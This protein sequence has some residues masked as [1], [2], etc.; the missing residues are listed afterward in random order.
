MEKV[1][2][3]PSWIVVR[4]RQTLLLLAILLAGQF[5]A[6]GQSTNPAPYCGNTFFSFNSTC[7]GWAAAFE[8]VEFNKLNFSGPACPSANRSS[9]YSYWDKASF[10]QYTTSVVKG[11]SYDISITTSPSTITTNQF[12]AFVDWNGDLDF[13]DA[14]EQIIT[15]QN[16]PFNTTW[17]YTRSITVPCGAKTGL[18]RMRLRVTPNFTVN[19]GTACNSADWG[20]T[21]DYDITIDAPSNPVANFFIPDT[22]FTNSPATFVNAN[23]SGYISHEWSTS[24]A[25]LPTIVGTNTNFLFAFPSAGTY[26]VRLT[27]A[28]CIGSATT[29]KNIVVVDP[30]TAPT[31]RFVG[32]RNNILVSPNAGFVSEF[33]DYYDF[34]SSGPTNYLWEITATNPGAFF[35]PIIG[36][37]NDKNV[38]VLFSD[39]ANHE[40]CMTASNAIGSTKLCK[41]DYLIIQYPNNPSKYE[42]IICDDAK[43]TLDSGVVYDPGGKDDPY[44]STTGTCQFVIDL[45]DADEIEITIPSIGYFVNWGDYLRVYDGADIS[46]K[47]LF[48]NGNNTPLTKTQTI[49]AKSGKATIEFQRDAWDAGDGFAVTWKAKLRNDGPIKAGIDILD[50]LTNDSIYNCASGREVRF[51]NATTNTRVIDYNEPTA[52]QWIFDYDPLIAYPA[53]FEDMPYN[54]DEENPTYVYS[55]DNKYT[56]RLVV[57]SCEG[58]DTAYRTLYIGTGSSVPKIDFVADATILNV[59]E[60]TWLRDKTIGWCSGTWSINPSTYTVKNGSLTDQDVEIQFNKAA[61][62][63]IT[64]ASTNDNGSSSRT[65]TDYISVIEYCVPSVNLSLSSASITRVKLNTMEKVSAT[66]KDGYEDFSSTLSTDLYAGATYTIEVDRNDVFDQADRKVWIDYNRDGAFSAS[67]LVASDANATT[68]TLT[69]SIT[70]PNYK[71]FVEGPT[72]MRVALGLSGTSLTP[73]GPTNV[74]EYEDYRVML[75]RDDMP[76]VITVLGTDSVFI[77]LGSS[78]KD[79]G[80]TAFDNR[81]GNITHKI[82]VDNQVDSTQTGVYVVT[83]NVLDESG[84][85]ATQRIRFVFVVADFTKPVIS[86][87]GNV[88]ETHE[89]NTPY[90]DAGATAMDDPGANNI[91]N[92]I[93]TANGVDETTLGTYEVE[94]T[95]TDAY[96]NTSTA[97]RTVNVVDRTAPVIT[98]PPVSYAIQV[99]TPFNN[100]TTVTDNYDNSVQLQVVSGSVSTSVFGTYKVTYTAVDASGNVAA[101][102]TCTYTVTDLIAPVVTSRSGTEFMLVNVNDFAFV[103][104]AVTATDNY[105]PAVAITRT[106]SFDI[107][108]LGDYT[109]TYTGVDGAGNTGTYVR[110]LRVVDMKAPTIIAPPIN[111][112]RWTVLDPYAGV[113]VVDNYYAPTTFTPGNGI[114]VVSSNVNMLQEGIYEIAYQAID[115]SG[116]ISELK[117]RTVNVVTNTTG[118]NDVAFANAINIYPNPNTGRFNVELGV[119]ASNN[120]K[121]TVTSITGQL[122][123]TYNYSDIVDG[124]LAIDLSTASAGVYLVQVQSDNNVATKRVTVSR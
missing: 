8:K 115:G 90:V 95:V 41:P 51:A 69:A 23:K 75:K 47:L 32:S 38:T 85:A 26:Q 17:N 84:L 42:N 111:I 67:E 25:G 33:V 107:T 31:V 39:T 71:D 56:I 102:V 22:V 61:R 116:N 78:Y 43:S 80:A 49:I 117:F 73:C 92:L 3:K 4:L 122:V 94:Y 99:G 113:T 46:G 50:K 20:E 81:E 65:K 9:G 87:V 10:P 89:V 19:A 88:V 7:D 55:A 18:T 52:V 2:T 12:G 100:P 101:P 1:F 119:A 27:S 21:F 15:N 103:E 77:E 114:D 60:S 64:Y 59:G 30:T 106:G 98:C 83:Y 11:S 37:F 57:R 13:N 29:T 24:V 5:T 121:I 79:A 54:G 63:T 53:G 68:K 6:S 118:I 14:N 45:C 108:K 58:W 16:I 104:P 70:I 72:R 40:V 93:V 35:F 48:Q 109:I 120:T 110:L 74:G 86:V 62:Y 76:P 28:N 44:S 124:K 82:K 34:S 36:S 97:K 112:Q 123:A 96:G 105:F 66:G 91:S